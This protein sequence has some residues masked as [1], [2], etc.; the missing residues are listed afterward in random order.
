MNEDQLDKE[1]C[2]DDDCE[3]VSQYYRAKKMHPHIPFFLQDENGDTYEF[4]WD[5]I[6]QYIA[7]FTKDS[8]EEIFPY[9]DY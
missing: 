9:P 4:G 1:R 2:F 7:N 3:V 5:I 8:G 6:Y